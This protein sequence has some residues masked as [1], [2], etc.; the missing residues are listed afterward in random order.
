MANK[1]DDGEEF[2]ASRLADQVRASAQQIWLA[3]L[4]AF[5]KAQEEGGKVF[6][7][8]V[9]EG[10]TLQR[11]SQAVAEDRLAEATSR[12]ASMANELGAKA[13]GQLDKLE[14]IFEDRVARALKRMGMP[15]ADEVQALMKRLDD[16]DRKLDRLQAASGRASTA[17]KPAPA[18]KRSPR[19]PKAD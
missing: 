18:R 10:A 11:K 6:D 7:T 2:T 8:L 16:L 3:G 5:S 4:G 9:K 14:T 17:R 15:S 19:K 13:S 12:M 1:Q